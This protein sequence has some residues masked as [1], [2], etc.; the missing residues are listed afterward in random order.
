M[1]M[2]RFA[3]SSLALSDAA[4]DPFGSAADDHL[5]RGVVVGHPDLVLGPLAGGL[6]IVVTDAEEGRHRARAL[7][8][9]RLHGL[10]PFDHQTGPIAEGDG[11]RGDEGGVLAQAV[12]GAG[13][14]NEAEAFDGVEDHQTHHQGGQLGVARGRQLLHVGVEEQGGEVAIGDL[15][16]LGGH[17]P[18]GMIDPGPAHARPLRPLSRE[19]EGQHR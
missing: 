13:G 17:L 7:V 4:G 3:P 10:A 9:G 5:A 16:G 6:G 12:A 19:G 1:G 15:G 11:P 14:G 18:G 2:T 8:G